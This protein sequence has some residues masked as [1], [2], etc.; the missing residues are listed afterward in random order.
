MDNAKYTGCLPSPPGT[1]PMGFSTW[2][3]G[4]GTEPPS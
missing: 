1:I 3:I 2:D 4:L